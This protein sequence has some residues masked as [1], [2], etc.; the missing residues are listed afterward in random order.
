MDRVNA[1]HE[2]KLLHLPRLQRIGITLKRGNAMT[3]SG[4]IMIMC[5]LSSYSTEDKFYSIYVTSRDPYYY[6][7][8]SRL[9]KEDVL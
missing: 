9:E 1:Y 6:T 7:L 3:I 5:I 4:S 2:K 8:I